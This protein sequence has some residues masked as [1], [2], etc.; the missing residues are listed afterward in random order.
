MRSGTR[1]IDAARVVTEAR[2]KF[3]EGVGEGAYAT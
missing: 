3:A 2:I 1:E